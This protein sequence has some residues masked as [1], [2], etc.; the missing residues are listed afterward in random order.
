MPD[1]DD[2]EARLASVERDVA[3]LREQSALTSSDAAAARVLA[4]GADRDVSEVRAEPRA[5]TQSLNALRETQLEQGR[6][7]AGLRQSLAEQGREMRE[8]FATLAAGMAQITALLTNFTGS[9]HRAA[10]HP[11]RGDLAG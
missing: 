11:R 10:L 9:Q 1:S 5:H 7:I 3:R 8:G 4:A 2:F 6:E